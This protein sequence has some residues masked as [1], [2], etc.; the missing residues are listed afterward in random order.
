MNK[1]I[2]STLKGK[3]EELRAKDL[4]IHDGDTTLQIRYKD[5]DFGKLEAYTEILNI[6]VQA[7]TEEEKL[8][9]VYN[10]EDLGISD[11]YANAYSEDSFLFT[12]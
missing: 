11:E 12:K 6:M 10:D 8:V 4:K 1:N 9:N 2:I 7:S 5:Q 3:I